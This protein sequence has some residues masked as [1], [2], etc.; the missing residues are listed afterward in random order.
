[1]NLL[2]PSHSAQL[3]CALRSPK[4]RHRGAGFRRA[5]TW[6]AFS[7]LPAMFAAN[8]PPPVTVEGSVSVN[9]PVTVQGVVEEIND[10]LRVPYI[11][12]RSGVS[13][14]ANVVAAFDVPDHKRLIVESVSFVALVPKECTS[15]VISLFIPG[16]TAIFLAPQFTTG[17]F[18]VDGTGTPV[19]TNYIGT[20]A[21]KIRIDSQANV[22][23]ELKFTLERNTLFAPGSAV[24][25]ATVSGYLVGIP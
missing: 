21:I 14:G 3:A 2:S 24:V 4:Q 19:G 18:A 13:D 20:H 17:S 22:T 25:R 12:S 15:V 5:I 16:G 6:G 7:I 23:D 11:V 1:M 8:G 9:G 10:V